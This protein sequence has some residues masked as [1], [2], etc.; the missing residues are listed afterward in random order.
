MFPDWWES[1]LVSI[2]FFDGEKLKITFMNF[3]P[4]DDPKF[5]EEADTALSNFL[6]LGTIHRDSYSELIYKNYSECLDGLDDEDRMLESLEF[7]SVQE[8]WGFVE[9]GEI[10]VSR[11]NNNDM[12]IYIDISCECKWEEEHG[13]SLVFRQGKMLT[14]VSQHDGE[15]TDADAFGKPDADDELLAK[16]NKLYSSKP[17]LFQRIVKWGK[18]K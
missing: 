17:S 13:L 7:G 15:L 14:R 5:I 11:R 1:G 9:P 2:P 18:G 4:Q 8:L 3:L 16:F 10:F 12:D 6:K